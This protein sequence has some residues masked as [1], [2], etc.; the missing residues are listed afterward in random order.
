MKR[1]TAV[2]TAMLAALLLA[3]PASAGQAT[4]TTHLDGAPISG[5][6]VDVDATVKSAGPV[7]PYEY[8]IQNECVFPHRGGSSLQHDDIVYWTD[9][10]PGGVP[11][12]TMPIDLGSVPTGSSCKVFLL[13]NNVVVK[14]ST[15]QYTVG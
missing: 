5:T 3:T 4:G 9:T 15:T 12:A 10:G 8:A 11:L 6:T 1:L 2:A 13:H 14:G 7:V